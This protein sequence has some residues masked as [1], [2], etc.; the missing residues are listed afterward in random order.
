MLCYGLAGAQ[1]LDS[2]RIDPYYACFDGFNP[3]CGCDG[4][5]YRSACAAEHR[6][7]VI[8]YISG[9]CDNFFIDFVPNPVVNY[10][11]EFSAY[12]KYPGTLVLQIYDSFARIKF[13]KTYY[14]SSP[15]QKIGPDNINF[16][17]FENGIFFVVAT[18]GG[19][20]KSVSVLHV[21]E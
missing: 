18:V 1:C 6:G 12:L 4:M 20:S 16:S 5:T 15:E 10:P 21:I 13:S 2:S 3:V 7:G 14:T 8:N 17:G 11:G 19:E 9:V